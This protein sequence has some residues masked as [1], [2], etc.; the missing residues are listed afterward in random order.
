MKGKTMDIGSIK[1]S[2][3]SLEIKH[4]STGESVGLTVELVS[5][6]DDRFK[7]IERKVTDVAMKKRARGKTFTADELE[8]NRNA[9]IAST[10]VGWKWSKDGSFGGEKLEFNS[11]NV[12]KVLAV[13]WIRG[14]IDEALAEP[15]NF[16]RG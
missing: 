12:A 16:F 3:F 11:S 6:T 8:E 15:A 10:I 5:P 1:A 9:L 4:P 13:D 2:T 14:Q 7:R